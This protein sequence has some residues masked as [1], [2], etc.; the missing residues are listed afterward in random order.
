MTTNTRMSTEDL[1]DTSNNSNLG[2]QYLDELVQDKN[3]TI[4]TSG[5]IFEIAQKS[6]FGIL[7]YPLIIISVYIF[8]GLI[9]NS[10]VF[11]IF[12]VKWK[13]NKTSVFIITLAVLDIIN[14]SVNMPIEVAVLSKPFS[15]DF[16]IFCKVARCISYI[17][18]ASY[19]FLLV[20]VAFDRY[21]MVCRPLKRMTL[22]KQYAKKTCIGAVLLGLLTQWP[23][24]II[25]GTFVFRIPVPQPNTT[26]EN[27][28]VF[29]Q[30]KTCLVTNYYY[31]ENPTLTY[32]FQGFLFVGHVII[33]TALT[34]TYII[35]GK[36]LYISSHTDL[37]NTGNKSGLFKRGLLSAITGSVLCGRR[38]E[39]ISA[40]NFNSRPV[41]ISTVSEH[42]RFSTLS[43]E[44][45]MAGAMPIITH[46]RGTFN[47]QDTSGKSNDT[48][49]SKSM[50]NIYNSCAYSTADQKVDL[51]TKEK[52]KDLPSNEQSNNVTRH[53]KTSL[54]SKRQLSQPNANR[55]S[56]ESSN[57]A[58]FS[59]PLLP[60]S[61]SMDGAQ[62][63]STCIEKPK[64]L[65]LKEISLKRNTLIMRMVTFTF[66]LSYLPF[67]I[68]VTIR[69]ANPDIP[70]KLSRTPLIAYHV[71]LRSYFFNSV[72]RPFIYAIMN[73]EYRLCVLQLL[74]IR[75][76]VK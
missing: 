20:A 62:L 38:T 18:T 40:E 22:G 65:D 31:H 24:V 45:E 61:I 17:T 60:R 72:I 8:I 41:R 9:G 70:G 28:S 73:K 12:S 56:T 48:N 16:D 7:V 47:A 10:I 50:N 32:A 66:I 74:H 13:R 51:H 71:F 33:F 76:C 52:Q 6:F 36:K 35:I 29:V 67:L 23:S 37:E 63:Y 68:I 3:Q 19:S 44:S 69:Y 55:S 57:S 46:Q 34:V 54:T 25:Y 64:K 58:L 49:F 15:F 27:S 59:H 42:T 26:I 30:G 43:T 21:L 1:T 14:C 39:S 2:F 11:Y 4:I 75:N 53:H 5:P